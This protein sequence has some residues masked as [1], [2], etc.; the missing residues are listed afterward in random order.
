MY[1]LRPDNTPAMSNADS[2]SVEVGAPSAFQSSAHP[3]NRPAP[4][5]VTLPLMLLVVDEF[6]ATLPSGVEVLW[7]VT[8]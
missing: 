4:A 7:P 2:V 8:M 3:N 5:T 1:A 6:S